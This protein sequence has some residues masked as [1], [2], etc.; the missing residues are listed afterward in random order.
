M[1]APDTNLKKQKKRHAG[2]LIGFV[3]VVV[4]AGIILFAF[5]TFQAD[6]TTDGDPIA[7]AEPEEAVTV[8]E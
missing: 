4:F 7:D 3:A 1:T 8:T 5:L 2:P 6:P